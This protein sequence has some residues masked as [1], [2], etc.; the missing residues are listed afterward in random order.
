MKRNGNKETEEVEEEEDPFPQAVY[1]L[2]E[3]FPFMTEE[4]LFD[5]LVQHDYDADR[6]MCVILEQ[7]EI[8]DFNSKPP[9]Q[10]RKKKKTVVA[11][12]Q[13]TF[14]GYTGNAWAGDK[15]TSLQSF[16]K[17]GLEVS[18]STKSF[19]HLADDA[20]SSVSPSS[21]AWK[22]GSG[23][24]VDLLRKLRL[25]HLRQQFPHIN[26]DILISVYEYNQGS[27][28][29]TIK[30]LRD[31]LRPQILFNPV[32]NE[33]SSSPAVASSL[34]I[35]K[36]KVASSDRVKEAVANAKKNFQ[37]EEEDFQL[38][39]AKR[40]PKRKKETMEVDATTDL[41]GYTIAHMDQASRFGVLRNQYFFQ[42]TR[43]YIA[44]HGQ[45]AR[46]LSKKVFLFFSFLSFSSKKDR[47]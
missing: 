27:T 20:E 2:Q 23:R 36:K 1:Q 35:P 9:V 17:T 6:V 15:P 37:E 30:S 41:H 4:D 32:Q 12:L 33:S 8:E 16:K 14:A 5:L 13:P 3:S 26:Q 28:S 7:G 44:G 38:V 45:L 10:R 42:A 46:Q 39:K 29:K 34:E 18:G 11:R 21:P 24:E 47:S 19:P 43:A 40:R 25:D 22:T 31:I